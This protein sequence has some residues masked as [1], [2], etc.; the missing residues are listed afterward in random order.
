[1]SAGAMGGGISSSVARALGFEPNGNFM[2][3]KGT[4]NGARI[5]TEISRDELVKLL[6]AYQDASGV[7]VVAVC[8][9]LFSMRPS[10]I[11]ALWPGLLFTLATGIPAFAHHLPPGM[12]EVDEFADHA[13]FLMGFN[14][15]LGG[16]DHL[17]AALLIGAVAARLGRGGRMTLPGAAAA[18]AAGCAAG[19]A[20]IVVPGGEAVIAASVVAGVAAVVLKAGRVLPALAAALVVFFVWTSFKYELSGLDVLIAAFCIDRGYALLHRDRDFHAFETQRG[21]RGWRH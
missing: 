15:P 5:Q 16:M 19:V 8:P 11:S 4:E 7:R 18:L 6:T 2:K 3:T 13:S 20:G 10:P 17:A 1:M 12:E 21:L 9:L 14:H